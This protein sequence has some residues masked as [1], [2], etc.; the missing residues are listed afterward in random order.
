MLPGFTDQV[1]ISVPIKFPIGGF[2]PHLYVTLRMG[3]NSLIHC[4]TLSWL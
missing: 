3:A 1:K 4:A 2:E